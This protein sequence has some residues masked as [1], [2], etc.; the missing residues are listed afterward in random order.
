MVTLRHWNHKTIAIA[1]ARDA[2]EL[3]PLGGLLVG[4]A[5]VF[6]GADNR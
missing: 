4:Y 1:F 3:L 5:Q 6:Q 2:G